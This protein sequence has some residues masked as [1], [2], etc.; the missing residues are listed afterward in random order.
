[1]ADE[2][3]RPETGF[4]RSARKRYELTRVW[5]PP[6][7]TTNLRR[8]RAK[9]ADGDRPTDMPPVDESLDRPIDDAIELLRS[10]PFEELQRRGWHF[11]PNHFYWPLNDVSFLRAHPELWNGPALPAEIDW[12]LDG[13][14]ELFRAIAR[15]ARELDDV[16][17]GAAPPGGF[18]WD[19]GPFPRSDATLYYC[20]IRHLRPRRVVEV[21][22]GWS[23]LML[24]RALEANGDGA[25]VTLVE[26]APN[27]NVLR[28]LPPAWEMIET[29]VQFAGFDCFEALRSGDVLFYD[30]SHCVHTG[31]DVNWIFFKVLP[32]LSAGVWIHVHDLGWPW[33]YPPDWVLDEGLSWNEQYLAQAFLMGNSRYRARLVLNMVPLRVRN[34][35]IEAIF[36]LPLHGTSVWI[37]KVDT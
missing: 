18:A 13:Q 16:P 15:Y 21:G 32:R 34:K 20:L 25:H 11:Q 31:S 24:R 1:M 22:A 17:T 26:P 23:S 2:E 10:V 30:G 29:Q 33:D 14:A 6:K 7:W 36:H 28:D 8:S 27:R 35:E 19:A 4:Q 3:G 9:A 5:R 12:D 37:Q